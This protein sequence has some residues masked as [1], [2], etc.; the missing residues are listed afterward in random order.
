M[1]AI[2]FA[3][4][5]MLGT[6]NM[7]GQHAQNLLNLKVHVIETCNEIEQFLS[8]FA[9]KFNEDYFMYLFHNDEHFESYGDTSLCGLVI[10]DFKTEP[11]IFQF[12][13]EKGDTTIYRIKPEVAKKDAKYIYDKYIKKFNEAE[14][15]YCEF[16]P[17]DHVFLINPGFKRVCFMEYYNKREAERSNDKN[18]GKVRLLRYGGGEFTD[19]ITGEERRDWLEDF[20]VLCLVKTVTDFENSIKIECDVW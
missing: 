3:I 4:L 9:E 19:V 17:G 13:I 16:I 20:S 14:N 15:S 6:V 2:Y 5:M 1:R 8:P 12:I 10:G 7:S 11:Q 18:K